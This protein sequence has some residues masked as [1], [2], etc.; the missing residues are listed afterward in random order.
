MLASLL[1]EYRWEVKNLGANLP[2]PYAINSIEK[3]K[4]EVVGISISQVHL[5][6]SLKQYINEIESLT[7]SPTAL[8]G[9]V[10]ATL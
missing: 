4:P 6:P 9:E 5:L 10:I 3:W 8:V 7:Y 1:E 2:L